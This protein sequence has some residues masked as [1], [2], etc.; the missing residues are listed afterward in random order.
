MWADSTP[1][2]PCSLA[3]TPGEPPAASCSSHAVWQSSVTPFLFG[4]CLA[5]AP[6]GPQCPCS[7]TRAWATSS[8]S[9]VGGASQPQPSDP[10]EREARLSNLFSL[11]RA[12]PRRPHTHPVLNYGAVTNGMP[13]ESYQKAG[14]SR[15]ANRSF[16]WA[17]AGNVLSHTGLA[18]IEYGVGHL[19]TPVLLVLG[20]YGCGAVTAVVKHQKVRDAATWGAL[21]QATFNRAETSGWSVVCCGQVDGAIPHLLSLI[22]PARTQ[23]AEAHPNCADEDLLPRVVESNIWLSVEHIISN[24]STVR[25]VPTRPLACRC[26][27]VWLRP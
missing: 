26:I 6:T 15:I 11:P 3:P 22:E 5:C 8:A 7:S 21:C 17:V 14:V 13:V 10:L 27:G 20:H 12:L 2:A 9:A 24:S 19:R 1:T 16:C 25:S 23:A 4:A 18:S